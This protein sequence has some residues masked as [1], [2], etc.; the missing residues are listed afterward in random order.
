MLQRIQTLFL[1]LVVVSMGVVVSMPIWHK[2]SISGG[3]SVRLTALALEYNQAAAPVKATDNIY[4]TILALASA[5]I[6][7]FSIT[8]FKKRVFQMLL[9][10][11]NSLVIAVMMGLCFYLIFRQGVPMFEPENQGNYE[12]GFFAAVAGLLSNMIANRFIRRDEMLVKS[13]DRMR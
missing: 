10:T 13:A 6:A 9:G 1:T 2:V 7:V 11:L 5:A 12:T 3:E 8:Q 4:I